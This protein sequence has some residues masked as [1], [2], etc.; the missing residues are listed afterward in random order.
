MTF[1]V[2]SVLFVNL[3]LWAIMLIR[4]KRLFS[5]DK[6]I[7]KTEQKLNHL[8]KEIDI[9]AD[10][11][12]YLAKETS[13]RIKKEIEE[14]ERKME[15]FQEATNRLRDMI[16]EADK[17]NKGQKYTIKPAVDP[18][19]AY[20]ITMNNKKPEQGNLFEQNNDTY[21]NLRDKKS[22]D[23]AAMQEVPLIITKVFDEHPDKMTDAEKKKNL[24][25]N[26]RR[27]FSEGLSA[28]EIS[29]KLNCSITEVQ[30]IIDLL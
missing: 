8:I 2:I 20:E 11:D 22:I 4:F 10:R 12:T 28:D 19:A 29:K 16:A 5:T 14:A 17:I 15:L 1:F 27:L 23:G 26:V 6:I 25:M 21:S 24:S 18:D 9:A 3:I 30:F 7:E 13:K